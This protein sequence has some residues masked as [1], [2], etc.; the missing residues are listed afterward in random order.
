MAQGFDLQNSAIDR[1]RWLGHRRGRFSL[2]L[3]PVALVAQNRRFWYAFCLAVGS[4]LLLVQWER[5]ATKGASL[6]TVKDITKRNSSSISRMRLALNRKMSYN[7]KKT[8][9]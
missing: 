8:A 9:M 7:K 4:V 1:H 6:L 3:I 2:I 5:L